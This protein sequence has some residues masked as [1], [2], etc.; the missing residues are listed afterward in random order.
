MMVAAR[1]EQRLLPFLLVSALLHGFLLVLGPP[2]GTT[3]PAAAVHRALQATLHR[4]TVS[5]DIPTLRQAAA[6]EL[7]ARRARA[8]TGRSVA[9]PAR[10][11]SGDG[12]EPNVRSEESTPHGEPY[13]VLASEVMEQVRR[14]ARD[15]AIRIERTKSRQ[16]SA[17]AAPSDAR[18]D[19]SQPLRG[20]RERQFADGSVRI[21]TAWG[22]SYC[23][24][25][26]PEFARGGPGDGV[27]GPTNCSW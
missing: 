4:F 14:T 2:R 13:P 21:E 9:T 24:K 1:A 5:G 11:P 16:A 15:E 25:P 6:E 23:L 18:A 26:P 22:T 3:L 7:V 19:P 12:A 27:T 20:P 10:S 17:S 8:G